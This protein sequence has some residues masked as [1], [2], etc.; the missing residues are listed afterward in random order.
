MR[1]QGH[2]IVGRHVKVIGYTTI[3]RVREINKVRGV[4]LEHKINGTIWHKLSSLKF[5]RG[6][7]EAK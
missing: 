5:L 2:G 6:N 1:W 4:R 7:Y 3:T